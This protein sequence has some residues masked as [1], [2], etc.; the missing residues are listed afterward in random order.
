MRDNLVPPKTNDKEKIA[1]GLEWSQILTFFGFFASFGGIGLITVRALG[2][3]IIFIPMALIGLGLGSYFG[4]YRIKG[5]SVLQYRR[6]KKR[7]ENRINILINES[8]D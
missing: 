4:I 5:H 7:I 3:V 6:L 1:L 2:N 8:K